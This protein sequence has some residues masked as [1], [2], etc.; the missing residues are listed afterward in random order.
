MSLETV[1]FKKGHLLPCLSIFL[2]GFYKFL[3]LGKAL[4]YYPARQRRR[5]PKS[6]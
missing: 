4:L 6:L 5:M 3:D 2:R 1:V